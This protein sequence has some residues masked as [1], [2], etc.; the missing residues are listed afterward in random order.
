[1]S[2][3]MPGNFIPTNHDIIKPPRETIN[4]NQ[5]KEP[6]ISFKIGE[7]Y[8]VPLNHSNG[9]NLSE[10]NILKISHLY[11]QETDWHKREPG[12]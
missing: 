6:S 7:A 2:Y 12:K 8:Y 1:M 5:T 3:S 4:E 10:K 9:K 11:Q